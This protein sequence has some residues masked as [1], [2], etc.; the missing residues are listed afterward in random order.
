ML[1][2]EKCQDESHSAT[3]MTFIMPARGLFRQPACD[4]CRSLVGARVW[5][6]RWRDNQGGPGE[7]LKA[8]AKV[9]RMIR[10]VRRS[11]SNGETQTAE[12]QVP[13]L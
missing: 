7:Y 10:F 9:K 12:A 2:G 5:A 4:R 1:K 8:R 3:G 11:V 13:V 6:Y